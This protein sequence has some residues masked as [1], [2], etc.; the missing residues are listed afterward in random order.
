MNEK[1]KILIA[2]DDRDVMFVLDEGLEGYEIISAFD[3]NEAY[4]RIKEETPD[5]ILLD[6]MMP[7]LNGADLNKRLK[8][9]AEL[10]E[11]PVI[12][13]TGRTNMQGLFSAEG[14]NRVS[15]FLE[16]PFTLEV[17]KKEIG[18]VLA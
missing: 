4:S 1:K 6:I 14:E 17:L 5:L 15:G 9:D 13:I 12:I 16:K 3:G 18:R 10:K 11:I 7:E 2:E 8:N